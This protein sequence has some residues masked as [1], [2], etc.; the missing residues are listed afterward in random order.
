MGLRQVIVP[1][2]VGVSLVLLFFLGLMTYPELRRARD[3]ENARAVLDD[4]PPTKRFQVLDRIAWLIA[5]LNGISILPSV[6]SVEALDSDRQLRKGIDIA[7]A[8]FEAARPLSPELEDLVRAVNR[9]PDWAMIRWRFGFFLGTIAGLWL[10][11]YLVP[12]LRR[13]NAN[14]CGQGPLTGPLNS[15][16]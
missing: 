6:G 8:R 3:F 11:L 4:L 16:N 10:M 7:R 15:S 1:I 5:W 12:G 14:Q 13:I 9:A 2:C